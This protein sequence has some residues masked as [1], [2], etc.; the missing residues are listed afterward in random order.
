[1]NKVF[2][3]FYNK[4]LKI[5]P[6]LGSFQ[7]LVGYNHKY[8]N[9]SSYNNDYNKLCIQ[10]LKKINKYNNIYAKVFKYYLNQEIKLN[11]FNNYIPLEPYNNHI[12]FYMNLCK[13]N[14]YNKLK[15]K[16][17][18][19]DFMNKTN[20]YCNY[21]NDCIDTMSFQMS[22]KNTLPKMACKILIKQLENILEKK[23]YLPEVSIPNC[24]K[25]YYLYFMNNIFR[26]KIIEITDFLKKDYIDKCRNTIG[27]YDTPNGIEYYK[28][29]IEYT[30]SFDISP[31]FI[32]N[33]GLEEVERIQNELKDFIRIYFPNKQNI[34]LSKFFEYM[35]NNKEFNFKSKKELMDHVYEKQKIVEEN[36]KN[37]IDER[38]Y[39]KI[40][41]TEVPKYLQDESANAYVEMASYNLKKPSTYHVNTGMYSDMKKYNILSLT[42]HESTPGHFFQLT[43]HISK[44]IPEFMLYCYN[45]TAYIEGWGLYSESLYPYEN[46]YEIYGKLVHELMRAIRLVLD[47]GINC[48]KWSY[49]KAYN[50][51]K[52]NSSLSNKEIENEIL[53]YICNPTQSLNYKIGELFFKRYVAKFDDSKKAH[54]EILKY[55]PIPLCFLDNTIFK[56]LRN[57]RK[58]RRKVKKRYNKKKKSKKV[59]RKNL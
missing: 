39:H 55:G 41:I 16:E 20:E 54:S 40:K 11:D 21:I 13:G 19:L 58:T 38:L 2:D 46:K 32:H 50:Y 37:Y 22:N 56:C 27:I 7:Q 1:M 17:D 51:Y 8:L 18:F 29:N 12:L 44:K 47:T 34:A 26:N 4:Y 10:Y 24:I 49:D 43:Y 6:T 25:K 30:T 36:Y 9:K 33:L 5:Y 23:L 42:L 59:K 14:G 28:K 3:E 35:K 52:N 15:T 45:N 57:I 48:F 53:R 31:K